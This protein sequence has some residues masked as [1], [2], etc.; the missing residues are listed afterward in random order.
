MRIGLRLLVLVCLGCSGTS[1]PSGSSG[2]DSA[3]QI[4]P[5]L[6]PNQL[7]ILADD[8]GVDK[9]SLYDV[10]VGGERALTPA[11]D[12][13]AA[14][15]IVFDRGYAAPSCS[16][17]RA[18]LLTGDY[19]RNNG[20]SRAMRVGGQWPLS[21]DLTSLPRF[22]SEQAGYRTAWLG[23]WHLAS[24]PDD[25]QHPKEVGFESYQGSIFNFT[26]RGSFV[27]APSYERWEKCVDGVPQRVE[28]YA[29]EDTVLD[30]LLAIETLPEPWL[31][32]V[33]FNAPHEPFHRPPEGW[34][35]REEFD[36][37]KHTQFL[38]AIE[39]VDIG[40]GIILEALGEEL[41][42][43]TNV[44]FFGDNGT[45]DKMLRLPPKQG[46]GSLRE[47][48]VRI[49]FIV[50]GPGVKDPGRRASEF[51][52]LMDV[53]PTL[54]TQAG[55]EPPEGIAGRDLGSVLAGE[56]WPEERDSL[57]WETFSPDGA[58]HG[59]QS[60]FRSYSDGE[61]KLIDRQVWG[62]PRRVEFFELKSDAGWDFQDL[63][64]GPGLNPVQQAAF[65]VIMEDLDQQLPVNLVESPTPI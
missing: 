1:Q 17:S 46:K 63:M 16:P 23:K 51:A 25:C 33:S 42:S 7:I 10:P 2:R 50:K 47:S 8:L 19:P 60:W 11:I 62:M 45:P 56:D 34:H 58:Y 49:P 59:R 35:Y 28:I 53:L 13:L 44:W 55:V 26:E 64:G 3:A 57:L 14:E 22:L 38:A 54:A 12:S 6:P 31:I 37:S 52:H 48:G 15:G 5:D 43:R 24:Y 29:T 20:I 36:G 61:Y 40:T 4:G 32:V 39:S 9:V 65:E 27:A 30:T 18:A 41:S 21:P